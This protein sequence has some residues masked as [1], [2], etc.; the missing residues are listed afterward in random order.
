MCIHTYIHTRIKIKRE[1]PHTITSSNYNKAMVSARYPPSTIP[2]PTAATPA[3][4]PTCTTQH[5]NGAA[6]MKSY[7][8]RISDMT[9]APFRRN[10]LRCWQALGVVTPSTSFALS[11]LG[12]RSKHKLL[13]KRV[14]PSTR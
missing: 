8:T 2:L 1:I 12:H 4:I 9:S 7:Y 10:T 3:C 5:D 13:G 11:N 6:V 14:N